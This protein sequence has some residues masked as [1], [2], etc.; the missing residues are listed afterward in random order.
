MVE[1]GTLGWGGRATELRSLRSDVG[2]IANRETCA[3]Q[4]RFAVSVL[5][6][7]PSRIQALV[8]R[9]DLRQKDLPMVAVR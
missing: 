8:L 2:L 1:R 6:W 3:C 5:C 9:T 4:G 7:R